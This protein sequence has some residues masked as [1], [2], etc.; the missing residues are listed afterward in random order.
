MPMAPR[1]SSIG[2]PSS[3]GTSSVPPEELR[4]EPHR[5]Q[6]ITGSAI[7]LWFMQ[8]LLKHRKDNA[9][10]HQP[11]AVMRP[12]GQSRDAQ[13]RDN[14]AATDVRA[15]LLLLAEGLFAPMRRHTRAERCHRQESSLVLRR[16]SPSLRPAVLRATN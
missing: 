7:G 6:V 2:A 16:V 3:P 10:L 15:S 9:L 11:R 4:C 5:A 12:C 1:P 14:A 13:S 8:L